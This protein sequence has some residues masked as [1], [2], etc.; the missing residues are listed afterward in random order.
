MKNIF[1]TLVAVC[2][3]LASNGL[4]ARNVSV[5]QARQAAALY[6]S[7]KTYSDI[8]VS[9]MQ[10]VYQF[11][12]LKLG[13]PSGYIFNAG[14][15]GWVF[16]SA[17][18]A[19][20]PIL[21][22]SIDGVL[23]VNNLA[24]NMMAFSESLADVVAQVQVLDAST[25]QPEAD[26]WLKLLNDDLPVGP[27]TKVITKEPMMTTLW[28]QG[29]EHNPTYNMYCPMVGNR[30]SVVGCVATALSQICYYYKY[31]ANPK[32]NYSYWWEKGGDSIRI[33][34]DT[35]SFDYSLMPRVALSQSSSLAE[36]RATSSLCYAL[37]VAVSMNYHP[38]GS[39]AYSAA[40]ADQMRI[41][42]SY[43][44]GTL[45]S[46]AYL[47]E[48]KFVDTIKYYLMQG[49]P[50]YM[51][52]ASSTGS[53]FDRDG[54]AW[55]V[56]GVEVDYGNE[57]YHMNWG[58]GYGSN[59]WYNLLAGGHLKPSNSHNYDFNLEQKV[60]V[61]MIPKGEYQIDS[62]RLPTQQGIVSVEDE[63]ELL[64]AYPNPATLQVTIPYT[65]SSPAE[66][67]IYSVDGKA[68]QTKRLTVGS[69][70]AVIN[71]S[72]M[73]AGIYIYRLGGASGKFIVQ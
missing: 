18:T 45:V 15:K 73:Q 49:H 68:V 66:L 12:N 46:R 40:V 50:L 55:V 28:D 53:G 6:M 63:V 58:W 60:I 2:L 41:H 70:E 27:A 3:L 11:D 59:S 25:P 69:G 19:A 20:D 65:I 71:V 16:L 35:V 5:D 48:Q 61:G 13:V 32:K 33:D 43:K 38:D 36:K 7:A 62:T 31:P 56:D 52:G 47:G 17:S 1:T 51:A 57:M 34:F 21:A 22:Y 10:L 14:D 30:Y 4:N 24:P 54:H 44:R 9:E 42:F 72:G 39:G 29:D 64:P 67:T 26:M 8:Q 23:D 37:G